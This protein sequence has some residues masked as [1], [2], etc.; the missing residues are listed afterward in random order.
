MAKYIALINGVR[1]L[2]NGLVT[3][4]GAADA[5]KIVET[6]ADGR[7]DI[8]LMPAGIGAD[9]VTANAGEALAA[10]DLVYITS[11][12]TVMKAAAGAAGTAAHGFVL[13]SSANGAPATVYF[14]GRNTARSGLTVGARYYLSETAGGITPTPV[15]TVGAKHQFVGK[16]ISATALDFEADDFIVL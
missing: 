13:A 15:A 6:G 10:G 4:T 2:V 9:A 8:S 7:L 1:N 16:A 3:S 11:G 14:E 12:G 5:N